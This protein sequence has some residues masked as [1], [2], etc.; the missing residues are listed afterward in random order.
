MVPKNVTHSLPCS[1]GGI[2]ATRFHPNGRNI[3]TAG[4]DRTIRLWNPYTPL[5]IHVFQS[6]AYQILSLNPSDDGTKFISSGGDKVVFLW[7]LP[8]TKLLR[9][10][11]GPH[12]HTQHINMVCFGGVDD[13]LII[14]G[15]YDTSVAIWDIRSNDRRPIQILDD[16]TDSV[17]SVISTL[18]THDIYT[19]CVDGKLRRYDIRAGRLSVDPFS[20]SISSLATSRDKKCILISCLDNTLWLL[21]KESGEV[22]CQYKGPK[23]ESFSLDC[24]VLHDDSVVLSG[25]EDGAIYFWDIVDGNLPLHVGVPTKNTSVISAID[26]HPTK[27]IVV[28][29]S[30]DGE[31]RLWT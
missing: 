17:T 26:A 8:S 4:A 22:L 19:G 12:G 14:S 13:N 24:A 16:A 29:G 30:H 9:K 5:L 3:L 10:F 21:D 7:D 11:G 27:K 15:S 6:H 1:S 23:N 18:C 31:V 2:F 20:S 25:S 28:C